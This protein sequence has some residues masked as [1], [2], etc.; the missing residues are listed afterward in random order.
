MM[1]NSARLNGGATLFFT[2]LTFVRVPSCSS[3]SLMT[4]MRRMSMRTLSVEL[5]GVAARGGLGVAVDHADLVAQLVDE[6]ADRLGLGDARRELAQRLRHQAGLQAHLRVAH[7]AFDLGLGGQRRHRVD[8]DDV[9]GARTDQR[10]GD[11]RVPAR[12]CRA[13]RSAGCPRPRPVSGRRNCRR[14]APRR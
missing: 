7:L 2:T 8:D 11:L 1:S 14:H 12:R 3:P 4:D 6:D 10:V 9:D 13:A 5:Q